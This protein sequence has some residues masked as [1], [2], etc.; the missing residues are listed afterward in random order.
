MNPGLRR[1][2]LAWGGFYVGDWAFVV[3]LSVYA[4][5]H[6]GALAVGVVGLVRMLPAAFAVPF[7]SV[8]TD[9]FPRHRLLTLVHAARAVTVAVGAVLIATGGPAPP[10]PPAR[11]VPGP[12]G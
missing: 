2:E 7:T 11:A 3:A 4:Y 5:H 8:L 12:P 10:P 1:L 6:G 9:R